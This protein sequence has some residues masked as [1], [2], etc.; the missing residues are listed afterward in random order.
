MDLPCELQSL[1]LGSLDPRNLKAYMATCREAR[2]LGQRHDLW[3]R[4]RRRLGIAPPKARARRFRTSL[5]LLLP[6]LCRVCWGDRMQRSCG[7]V[8]TSCLQEDATLWSLHMPRCDSHLKAVYKEVSGG[9][10]DRARSAISSITSSGRRC[11]TAA[12]RGTGRQISMAAAT[13]ESLAKTSLQ[14]TA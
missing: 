10:T 12:S 9:C 7:G 3:D 14:R 8:C 13:R 1:V 5:D 6:V 4:L 2:R 11:S